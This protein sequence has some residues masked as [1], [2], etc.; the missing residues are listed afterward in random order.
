MVK[1][2]EVK[3]RDLTNVIISKVTYEVVNHV[4]AAKPI[5]SVHIYKVSNGYVLAVSAYGA[6]VPKEDGENDAT[7]QSRCWRMFR[8]FAGIMGD[9]SIDVSKDDQWEANSFHP[10]MKWLSQVEC[11]M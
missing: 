4:S 11:W 7:Y 6:F 9:K 2:V 8:A 10:K 3:Q 1:D 5:A